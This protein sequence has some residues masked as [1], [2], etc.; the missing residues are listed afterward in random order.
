MD[1]LW[2]HYMSPAQL[3]DFLTR[4]NHAHYRG[5]FSEIAELEEENLN[6]EFNS[7]PSNDYVDNQQGKHDISNDCHSEEGDPDQ[8][9]TPHSFNY[10][11]DTEEYREFIPKSSKALRLPHP[12]L[13]N[14][15]D[16]HLKPPSIS[17]H[18][19]VQNEIHEIDLSGRS[20]S[21]DSRTKRNSEFLIDTKKKNTKNNSESG[22]YRYTPP[23]TDRKTPQKVRSKSRT[24]S[25]GSN[26]KS[27]T[28]RLSKEA[29]LTKPTSARTQTSV[30]DI[31]SAYKKTKRDQQSLTKAESQN[32]TT[33]AKLNPENS[34]DIKMEER[35]HEFKIL[36]ESFLKSVFSKTKEEPAKTHSKNGFYSVKFVNSSFEERSTATKRDNSPLRAKQK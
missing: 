22:K 25:G 13:I 19:D 34:V 10:E 35:L 24:Q 3:Q 32:S 4:R 15:T 2:A 11:S 9:H 27:W 23:F 18:N 8:S 1:Q 7:K 16:D 33:K 26:H 36:K 14:S 6:S 21:E 31:S 12:E 20:S 30:Q 28:S 5:A 17:I 29:N